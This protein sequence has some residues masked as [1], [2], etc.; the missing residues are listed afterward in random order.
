MGAI[1]ETLRVELRQPEFSE[2]YAESFQDAYLA[3]QIKVLR[4][5]NG[6]TQAKLAKEMD[7]TQTAISRIENVNYSSHNIRTLK[8]AARAF[9]LRLRV[10]FE[11]YGSLVDDMDKFSR[12][13]LQRLPR[14]KDPE[15][16]GAVPQEDAATQQE[17]LREVKEPNEAAEYS[18]QRIT[19]KVAAAEPTGIR[20]S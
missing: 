17:V 19:A 8:R 20:M 6:W 4:E 2:G 10:S 16:T 15:L 3:T 18:R 7:T 5:Q 1:S 9:R 13:N 11:T 12:E 14:E